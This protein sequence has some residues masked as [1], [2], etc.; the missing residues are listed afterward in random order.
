[1]KPNGPDLPA[2]P[3]KRDKRLD[4][5]LNLSNIA[6]MDDTD[7]FAE[8]PRT[9]HGGSAELLHATVAR[10]LG[11]AI[12]QGRHVAGEL[13]PSE[14]TAIQTLKI[15]R[16]AYRE[17]IRMLAAK[18]LVEI[19]PKSG[20]RVLPRS[21]WNLLDPDVLGWILQNNPP[22][23][24]QTALFDVR[25]IIEP[26]AAALAA[27]RRTQSHLDQMAEA[28][29]VMRNQHHDS[30]EGQAAD[31][32]FHRVL[33][34]AA[35]NEILSKLASLIG[36]SVTY[37]AEY[38]RAREVRRDPTPDHE[39]LFR[40]IAARRSEAARLVVS[41]L[42]EHARQDTEGLFGEGAAAGE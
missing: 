7:D 14:L 24:F 4:R 16:P 27:Q 28:L 12:I 22:E 31:E 38:K 8:L 17:G 37:I 23:V 11:I 29:E 35:D 19:R 26:A 9:E 40:A 21:Q 13:L 36:A 3:S 10:E 20:T 15:S 39:A 6:S 32:M 41:N 2:I 33:L 34:D 18:N 25:M 30:P 5:A 42:I 1:M